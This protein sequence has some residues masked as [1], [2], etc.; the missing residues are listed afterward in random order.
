MEKHQVHITLSDEAF[1]ELKE[2]E[3]ELK[4][5]TISDVIRSS[6]ALTKFIAMEKASGNDIIIRD[7]KQ[8]KEKVIATLR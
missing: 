2:L 3:K 1:K 7:K 5:A 8:N 6:V 4:V